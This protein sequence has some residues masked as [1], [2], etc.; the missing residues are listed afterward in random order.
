MRAHL[1]VLACS[2]ALVAMPVLAGETPPT[3]PLT[4]PVSVSPAA[5]IHFK[6]PSKGWMSCDPATNALLGVETVPEK[7]EKLFCNRNDFGATQFVVFH[8]DMVELMIVWTGSKQNPEIDEKIFE[9]MPED[10]LKVT[11]DAICA[12]VAEAQDMVFDT[13]ALSA[14]VISGRTCLVGR[15]SGPHKGRTLYARIVMVPFKGGASVIMF[16][17]TDA[18]SGKTGPILDAMAA[19]L[20]IGP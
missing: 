12:Q 1:S 17:D 4:D 20:T 8:S 10:G 19:S 16:M 13:C 14:K 11:S 7:L 9:V 15:L 3:V 5:G 2:L 6:V 18:D